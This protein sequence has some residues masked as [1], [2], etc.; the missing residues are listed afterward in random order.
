MLGRGETLMLAPAADT[1]G[2]NIKDF[3]SIGCVVSAENRHW[4]LAYLIATAF[5]TV[6]GRRVG[7]FVHPIGGIDSLLLG[8]RVEVIDRL[9]L[10]GVVGIGRDADHPALLNKLVE[11]WPCG[12]RVHTAQAS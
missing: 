10:I 8:Q 1:V 2:E 5:L 4:C 3:V 9:I 11:M 6:V 7:H 12:A